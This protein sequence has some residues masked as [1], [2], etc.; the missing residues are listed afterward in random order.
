[1]HNK[2]IVITPHEVYIAFE[3]TK[4]EGRVITSAVYNEWGCYQLICDYIDWAASFQCYNSNHSDTSHLYHCRRLWC[5]HSIWHNY[6]LVY[7]F[8]DLKTG[9]IH[10]IFHLKGK[11][12]DER[13]RLKIWKM[14]WYRPRAPN[15]KTFGLTP[16]RPEAF[17]RSSFVSSEETSFAE[18]LFESMMLGHTNK[19]ITGWL[20]GGR[21][22]CWRTE[23]KYWLNSS[24]FCRSD[25]AVI[26]LTGSFTTEGKL[27]FRQRSNKHEDFIQGH[28]Q[29]FA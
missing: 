8:Q 19:S 5:A 6:R 3:M 23:W 22:L 29:S 24:A 27:G 4:P 2:V 25:E 14:G 17:D 10:W 1:M 26:E 21:G 15:F 18:R 9:K 7:Y 28:L 20:V 11:V 16:S 13:L 12:F